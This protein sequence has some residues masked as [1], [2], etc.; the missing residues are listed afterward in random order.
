M[1]SL[2]SYY[3]R[4]CLWL[5]LVGGLIL[6]GIGGGSGVAFTEGEERQLMKG[7]IIEHFLGSA[8]LP[9]KDGVY[10]P[11]MKWN[12]RA[13]VAVLGDGDKKTM[14]RKKAEGITQK[15][16][17]ESNMNIK[18]I[19]DGTTNLPVLILNDI[20]NDP[21]GHLK[22]M[23]ESFSFAGKDFSEKVYGYVKQGSQCFSNYVADKKGI[24]GGL[25]VIDNNLEEND[26]IRCLSINL[27]AMSGFVAGPGCV[28]LGEP[29][30]KAV[31]TTK[32]CASV[33]KHGLGPSEPTDLDLGALKLLYQDNIYF[34]MPGESVYKMFKN[35]IN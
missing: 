1:S 28:R 12:D 10:T 3:R 14:L 35:S 20:S 11:I 22:R 17:A 32:K 25:I 6:F 23:M 30:I 26:A 15:M 9:V 16:N 13:F 8:L 27:L 21:S 5:W 29:N 24:F 34:G 2:K 18:Y 4:N 19:D 31:K 7:E 33:F